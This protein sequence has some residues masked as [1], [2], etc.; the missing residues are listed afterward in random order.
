VRRHE[1]V[2]ERVQHA[3]EGADTRAALGVA[4]APAAAAGPKQRASFTG[5]CRSARRGRC[6]CCGSLLTAA[7]RRRHAGKHPRRP[8]PHT[9]TCRDG[10][11]E[12]V[13]AKG[14]HKVEHHAAVRPAAQPCHTAASGA[15]AWAAAHVGRARARQVAATRGSVRALLGRARWACA[16][17][18]GARRASQAATQPHA[19]S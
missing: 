16:R 10:D 19:L 2:C 1:L 4:C 17:A 11:S 5:A 18:G 3:C 8:S 6:A 12:H 9:R 7:A 15:W 14:P 13:V